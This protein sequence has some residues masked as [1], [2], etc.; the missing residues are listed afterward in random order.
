MKKIISTIA[1]IAILT[2]LI[3]T[4]NT[5]AATLDTIDV[6]T[7]KTT[8]RPGEEV[9]VTIQ[10]GQDLGAYTFDV[11]YDN[12]IFEYVSAEGGTASDTTTKVRVVYFDSTGGSN[13]RTN[14]SVTFKAKADITTSNPTE[15]TVTAE[16]LANAD[17]SVT[18]DD[19]TIPIVKN[20]TVEP[21]YVDYTLKLEHTG[22]I[23]KGKENQMT[24]SYSSSMGRYYEHARLVA[25]A[26]SPAGATVR[27][28]ATDKSRLE[29]DIIQSGWGDAQGYKI[30]GKDVSQVLQVRGIFSE[31]GDYTITLKL[32]DRDNSDSVIAQE[33]FNF[34][35]QEETTTPPE[36]TPPT[37]PEE[38]PVE[39]TV[40]ET[41]TENEV[42]KEETPT[43]LPKTGN[44]IYIPIIT[45]L[46]ILTGAYV[47]NK[48]RK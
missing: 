46:T 1:I 21:Q 22:N 3:F 43:T 19:I 8:V 20:V 31:V 17:A 39:P 30:G 40:P 37:T 28:L 13:P 42:K 47:Y 34:T 23:I 18:F 9:K 12:N 15:F 27:L 48:K 33:T 10:F 2:L 26:T 32:I 24:L 11:S 38:T 4:G 35:A 45:I 29:H 36:T 7:D 41:T 25:E 16:G 5:Y 44:N 14:M 6:N